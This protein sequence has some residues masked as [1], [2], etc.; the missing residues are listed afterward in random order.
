MT[1]TRDRVF[2]ENET[3]PRVETRYASTVYIRFGLYRFI[4]LGVFPITPHY[5][6]AA[7][8]G[9]HRNL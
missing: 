6:N 4:C 5:L 8:S 7:E 1:Q 9:E 2:L 3:R